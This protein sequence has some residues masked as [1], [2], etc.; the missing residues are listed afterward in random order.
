MMSHTE[1]VSYCSGLNVGGRTDWHLP[2]LQQWLQLA[3]GCDGDTG[4]SQNESYHSDC[5]YNSTTDALDHCTMCDYLQGPTANG[6]YWPSGMGTCTTNFYGY[7][8]ST[9][10][11]EGGG[12]SHYWAFIPTYNTAQWTDQPLVYTRCVLQE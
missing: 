6:C 2:T 3:R 8:S 12:F 1:A 10:S 5:S 4:T 9:I 7:W 11:S